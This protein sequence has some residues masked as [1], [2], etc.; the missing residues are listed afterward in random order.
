[1]SVGGTGFEFL[2][3]GLVLPR[4][5]DPENGVGCYVFDIRFWGVSS[6]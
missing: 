2:E 5:A 6:F 4:V 1:M 3:R